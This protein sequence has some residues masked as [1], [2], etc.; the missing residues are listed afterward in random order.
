MCFCINPITPE[1]AFILAAALGIFKR[2]PRKILT[3]GSGNRHRC[4][5]SAHPKNVSFSTQILKMEC[6]VSGGMC[7]PSVEVV[8]HE[9]GHHFPTATVVIPTVS[10]QE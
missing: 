2:I 3:R 1:L 5:I 10:S 9:P 8:R 6:A 7:S 4:V